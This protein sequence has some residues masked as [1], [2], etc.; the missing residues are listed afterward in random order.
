MTRLTQLALAIFFAISAGSPASAETIAVIAICDKGQQACNK[1]TARSVY[2]V[3]L[4]G[5]ICFVP[6]QQ[7]LAELGVYDETQ[8]DIRITCE[9]KA[10]E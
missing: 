5:T 4:D 7:K 9:Q 8:D 6:I 10:A 2:R 3:P 1:N